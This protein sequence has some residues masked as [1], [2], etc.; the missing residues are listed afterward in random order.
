MAQK[1]PHH[2]E[3]TFCALC[4]YRPLMEQ[5]NSVKPSNNPHRQ[6]VLLLLVCHA[7]P[8]ILPTWVCTFVVLIFLKLKSSGFKIAGRH[9]Y[10]QRNILVESPLL[11]AVFKMGSLILNDYA[12]SQFFIC[13]VICVRRKTGKKT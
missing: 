6:F 5:I 10:E 9:L 2:P 3:R 8:V 12:Q 11:K 1:I 13:D 4:D 7:E